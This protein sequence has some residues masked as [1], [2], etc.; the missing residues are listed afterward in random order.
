PRKLELLLQIP[1]GALPVQ[2]GFVTRGTTVALDAYATS[3]IEYAFY[4]PAPGDFAHYPAHVGKDGALVAAAAVRPAV[5]HVVATAT[6]GDTAS[7]EHVSQEG[8]PDAV[9]TF[10]GDANLQRLDLSRMLWRLR[11]RAFFQRALQL[12]QA[13]HVWHDGV[14]SYALLHGE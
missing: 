5:L 1:A 9:L 13:R 8:T 10:L 7:W 14:W 2:N 3:K 12:L 6:E 11:D 4:F